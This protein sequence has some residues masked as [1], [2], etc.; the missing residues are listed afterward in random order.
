MGTSN[1]AAVQS[2]AG[3]LNAVEQ[4]VRIGVNYVATLVDTLDPV[5]PSLGSGSGRAALRGS[6]RLLLGILVLP[7]Q[8]M[9]TAVELD[10]AAL[11]A[12]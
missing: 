2:T 3:R 8:P 11:I 7:G 6:A 12:R 10:K 1:K 9:P 5:S 4:G